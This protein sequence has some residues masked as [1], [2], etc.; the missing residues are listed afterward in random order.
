[1]TRSRL[2][3]AALA[4]LVPGAACAD[5]PV[6]TVSVLMKMAEHNAAD[7]ADGKYV[8]EEYF[9]ANMLLRYFSKDFNTAYGEAFLRAN[10]KRH[11]LLIDWDP[12]VGGQ[13]S[14]PLKDVTYGKPKEKKG[15][16]DITVSFN[17]TSC[18]SDAAEPAQVSKVTF[19][20]VKDEMIP[21]S[22]FYLIDDVAHA[23]Q[24]SLRT[25]LGE[26]GQ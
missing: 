13:D 7:P 15:K 19:T 4:F 8:L 25:S 9:S 18:Y 2:L 21:G 17:S 3:L 16:I 22:V 1:M 20:L 26:L 5:E 14:C 24:P 12:I 11:E 23:G 10:A 6:D